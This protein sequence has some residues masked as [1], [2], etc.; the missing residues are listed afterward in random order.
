MKY[1]RF[2]AHYPK[3][4]MKEAHFLK[5]VKV[6]DVRYEEVG[7]FSAYCIDKNCDCRRTV[8]QIL[9]VNDQTGCI[10]A[11]SYGW[12]PLSFYRK[13]KPDW[14]D[15]EILQVIS[16]SI[17][18]NVKQ[19]NPH[20][21]AVDLFR[22]MLDNPTF[23]RSFA[24]QYARFKWKMGMKLPKDIAVNLGLMQPCSCKSGKLFRLCCAPKNRW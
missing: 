5:K 2:I 4:G 14:E 10:A 24:Q 17:E 3:M 19:T 13:F 20:P 11:I 15:E 6:G 7:F 21:D 8:V 1:Q 23:S 22:L 12:E 9:D 16:P 18:V